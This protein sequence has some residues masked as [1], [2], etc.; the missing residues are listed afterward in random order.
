MANINNPP[1]GEPLTEKD[2]KARTSWSLWFGQVLRGSAFL[3]SGTT[4]NRPPLKDA[5]PFTYYGDTT[6]GIPV[7][8]NATATG[9]VNSAGA[10]V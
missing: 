5:R 10:A 8:V 2:G 4:A 7:Y 9:W 1:L 3:G 6:L